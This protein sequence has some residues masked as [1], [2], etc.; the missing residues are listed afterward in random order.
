MVSER[1]MKV[2]T[3]ACAVATL[4]LTVAVITNAARTEQ[5]CFYDWNLSQETLYHCID[6]GSGAYNLR[7]CNQD[8][9]TINGDHLKCMIY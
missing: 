5:R 1:K 8:R 3:I 4:A 9:G 7:D 6:P 2:V